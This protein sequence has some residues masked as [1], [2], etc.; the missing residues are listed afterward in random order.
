MN[1]VAIPE[2]DILSS[3]PTP[4]I[5]VNITMPA[6]ILMNMS[7]KAMMIVSTTMF[8]SSSRNEP[9]ANMIAIEVESE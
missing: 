1:A 7:E 5:V 6:R 2:A 8:V 3:I 9:Y 4:A